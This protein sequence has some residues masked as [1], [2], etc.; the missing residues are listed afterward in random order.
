MVEVVGGFT[1]SRIPELLERAGRLPGGARVVAVVPE[2]E[3]TTLISV[4]RRVRVDYAGDSKDAPRYLLL[5]SPRTGDWFP[6]EARKE[7]VFYRDVAP[8]SPSEVLATCFHV[9]IAGSDGNSETRVLLEDLSESHRALGDWPVPPA[10]EDCERLLDAYARFHAAWWDD[11]R[12]GVSVGRFRDDAMLAASAA[13]IAERWTR[14]RVMLGDRLGAERAERGERVMRAL[15]RLADRHRS[16]R[17]L[18]IVHG[19]AHV[20]NALLPRETG[21]TVRVIDWPGWR[22]DFAARDL[23]YMMALH[24]YPERRGRLERDLLRHY[25]DRLVAHG[26]AGYDFDA[27]RSDYRRAVVQQIAIPV[28]QA[29]SGLPPAIWWSHFERAMLAFDDLGCAELLD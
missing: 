25:H 20:W 12:L 24:W 18:T 27:L 22:I 13:D 19:D 8:H 5:K 17:H 9:T 3:R 1:A 10:R 21:G 7:A 14:F 28:W 4:L 15:P 29:T 11:A 16:R 23:A 26:V 6:E 2:A